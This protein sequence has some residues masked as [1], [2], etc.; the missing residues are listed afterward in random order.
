MRAFLLAISCFFSSVVSAQYTQISQQIEQQQMSFAQ[1]QQWSDD[2]L[3]PHYYGLWLQANLSQTDA[4]TIR[5]FRNNSDYTAAYHF[6]EPHWHQEVVNRADPEL[7]IAELADVKSPELMCHYFAALEKSN[8][9]IPA[10]WV[11]PLWM[12]GRSQPDHCDVY[13]I[14]WLIAQSDIDERVWRRQ[15]MAFYSRNGTLLN[16]LN[17]FYVNETE[18]QMGE[19]LTHI[20]RSPV[21][22]LSRGYN[23]DLP[24]H[25]ELGLATINRLAFQDPKA[26]SNL[27]GQLLRATP[28][29]SVQDRM[30]T[31]KHLG[32]TMAK[33]QLP[34]AD[35]WLML[36]DP[37]GKDIE[38]QH[39]RF[40][41]ALAKDDELKVLEL[42]QQL[43]PGLKN[44][45]QFQ[46]WYGITRL[47]QSVSV[48]ADNP[49]LNLSQQ[50]SYYGFLA[51]GLLGTSPT[52]SID[53]QYP[54][55]DINQIA[56]ERPL[57]RAKALFDAQ[58]IER[59]Q[60]EWNLWIAGQPENIRHTAAE[61]ALGWGWYEKA[62]QAAGQARRFD[63]IALRYPRAFNAVVNAQANVLDIPDYWIYGVM[64]QESR[65]MTAARS[66]A[67]AIGLMQLMPA[68]AKQT[69]T[70]YKI[71]YKNTTDLTDPETNIALGSHYLAELLR[72]Y[73]NPIYATAAYN[74]GP[75]RVNNWREQ[76]PT[77]MTVWIESIPFDETRNYVKAVLT[78]AQVYALSNDSPW[79]LSQWTQHHT[80]F[81]LNQ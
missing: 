62:S 40:Q 36:A 21:H 55:K 70:R 79:Q 42:Y 33:Q 63:L 52:L 11:E 38:V 80:E 76:L 1:L 34:E 9:R 75:S 71:P 14:D 44:R 23:P 77:D 8:Q 2:V 39:W 30:G 29:F 48:E 4:N 18:Q 59:A 7:I 68:T 64:R 74:A 66:S 60:V 19:F 72:R 46:Y 57:Q 67:G 56:N 69:A 61:L 28:K 45:D 58:Q 53:N 3:Y 26:A 47:R 22:L 78:F 50:R 65:Y 41:I 35:Y 20:Y 10:E 54:D 25:R 43:Q 13:M 6:L 24:K 16:Y 5:E 12:T 51:A 49:L 37:D 73:D 32:I 31:S 27:W 17:R 15:L 81:A